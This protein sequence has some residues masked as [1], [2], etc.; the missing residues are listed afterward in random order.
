MPEEHEASGKQK[1]DNYKDNQNQAD[2]VPE[3]IAWAVRVLSHPCII[4]NHINRSTG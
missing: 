4:G 3:A 1:N 2:G